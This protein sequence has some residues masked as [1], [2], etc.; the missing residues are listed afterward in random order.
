MLRQISG[1]F[2]ACYLLLGSVSLFAFEDQW[3]FEDNAL[4]K[5][6]ESQVKVLGFIKLF[7][8]A[9]YLEDGY[10]PSDFPGDFTYALSIRYNRKIK[11]ETLIESAN[12]ILGD[13]YQPTKISAIE[14]KLREINDYYVDV[15]K[16]DEY[17]LAY[18]P[19]KGTTLLFN[20]EPQVTIEGR[21]FAEIYF[22]IWLGGHPKCKQLEKDLLAS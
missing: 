12:D 3:T 15:T 20:G 19:T 10:Q 22:S 4:K 5:S 18:S 8:A 7:D 13:L 17:A 6:G 21:E 14:S 11:R 2:F 1:W 9:L 16:G